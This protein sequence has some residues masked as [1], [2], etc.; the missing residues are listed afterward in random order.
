MTISD[1]DLVEMYEAF[2]VQVVPSYRPPPRRNI[3]RQQFKG[4][5]DGASCCLSDR[6]P[7]GYCTPA[8]GARRG[9]GRP[10]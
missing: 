10:G 7:E 9:N 6:V 2:A 5:A 8:D 1:I 4:D 3:S